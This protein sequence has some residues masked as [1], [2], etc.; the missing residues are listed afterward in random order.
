MI[1][2]QEV[3]V[4]GFMSDEWIV[5]CVLETATIAELHGPLTFR[6]KGESA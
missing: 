3:V 1:G 6:G 2:M 4:P 5:V